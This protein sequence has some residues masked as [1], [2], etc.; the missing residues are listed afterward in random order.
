[1]TDEIFARE[2]PPVAIGRRLFT[3][4]GIVAN[5]MVV[6]MVFAILFQVVARY[7]VANPPFWT[8]ELARYAMIWAGSL[9]AAL[10]FW[11]GAD[12]RFVEPGVL[13]GA[14]GR[15]IG[16]WLI[17]VPALIFAGVLLYEG[18][19]G[20]GMMFTRGFIGRNLTRTSEA[21]D[22]NMA[23]ITSALP[24]MALLILA[25]A[26]TQLAMLLRR[27]GGVL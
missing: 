22:V 5:A 19:F 15:Q 1:V 26:I 10:A 23:A 8:E 11:R 20:P 4:V 3:L 27:R 6:V 17:P 21:L 18:L 14:W 2:E 9:G 12:P 7:I 13:F 25:A 24:V 16:A